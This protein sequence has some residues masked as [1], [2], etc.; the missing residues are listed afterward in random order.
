MHAKYANYIE[1]PVTPYR[2][3]IFSKLIRNITGGTVCDLGSHAV[4]HYWALGYAERADDISF[5]DIAQEALEIQQRTI[6]GLSPDEL[7][8]RY[9]D[10]LAFLKDENIASG[11]PEQMAFA[12]HD[13][14]NTL[15]KFDFLNDEPHERFDFVLAV[16]SLEIVRTPDEFAKAFQSVR[17][18]LKE[19]TGQL[20]AVIVPYVSNDNNVQTLCESG[21]EG[22]LNPGLKEIQEALKNTDFKHASV[23]TVKT[24]MENYPDAYFI[25]ASH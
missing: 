24:Y 3:A 14:I 4:G 9:G 18:L 17:N 25:S 15:E 22:T 21:L 7:I 16:E 6:D 20:L 11:D 1:T 8:S 13:K 12:I 5:Y 23:E 10:T 2:H 19:N